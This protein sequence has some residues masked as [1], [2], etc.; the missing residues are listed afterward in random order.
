MKNSN[1]FMGESR[2]RPSF[3]RKLLFVLVSALLISLAGGILLVRYQGEQKLLRQS[4]LAR[5]SAVAMQRQ[6][7]KLF[8]LPFAW[9]VRKELMKDNYEQIDEYFGQLI[10]KKGFDLIMLVTPSGIIRVSTD[11]KLQGRFF[12]LCYPD[13]NLNVTETLSYRL[14]ERKSMFVVPIMGL[15]AK[16]GTIVFVYSYPVLSQP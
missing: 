3:F 8:A 7:L 6:D 4:A 12:L 11:R 13:I 1:D 14:Q 2:T 10:S 5:T 15:N 16:I 9:A